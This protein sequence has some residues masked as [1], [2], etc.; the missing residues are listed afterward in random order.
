[1]PGRNMERLDHDLQYLHSRAAGHMPLGVIERQYYGKR[2]GGIRGRQ[3]MRF[4]S[5][6]HQWRLP[7]DPWRR[8]VQ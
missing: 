3:L 8:G 4:P 2:C 1:M 6:R 7:Y 5:L